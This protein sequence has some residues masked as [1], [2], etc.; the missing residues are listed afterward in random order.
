MM[1]TPALHRALAVVEI[2]RAAAERGEPAPGNARV[3]QAL[4]ITSTGTASEAVKKA[5]AMGLILVHRGQNARVVAAPDGGWRTVGEVVHAH[6]PRVAPAGQA[7]RRGPSQNS[8]AAL[9]RAR[10]TQMPRRGPVRAPV[11]A[12]RQAL[13]LPGPAAPEIPAEA[14]EPWPAVTGLAS[15]FS[16]PALL[17]F[18]PSTAP[19][20]CG[21]PGA[22]SREDGCRYPLGTPRQPGFRFCCEPRAEY[23]SGRRS[24]YC[25]EH[26]LLCHRADEAA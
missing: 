16:R 12:G 10:R 15:G 13:S 14:G 1:G 8:A 6:A 17:A 23:P 21:S 18:P 3:A 11:V 2:M 7:K 20:A 9:V 26:H 4:G 19:A 25:V 5:E 24:A 22:F